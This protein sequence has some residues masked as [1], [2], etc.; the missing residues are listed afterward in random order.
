MTLA[1]TISYLVIHLTIGFSVAYL[2]TGSLT[3][4][5]GIALIEPLANAVAYFFHERAWNKHS[6]PVAS[7]CCAG[8]AVA[9]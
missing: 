2:F 6:Q 3:I 9:T 1:K 8:V 5:G 4:A 7:P